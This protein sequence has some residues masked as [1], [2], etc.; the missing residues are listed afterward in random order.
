MT[1][2]LKTA[3]VHA[4]TEP[5]HTNASLFSHNV[6]SFSMWFKIQ[7]HN[8]RIINVPTPKDDGTAEIYLVLHQTNQ[9]KRSP[10]NLIQGAAC[11]RRLEQLISR[12][13]V[14]LRLETSHNH[15]PGTAAPA[16]RFA[17][18]FQCNNPPGQ[19]QADGSLVLHTQLEQNL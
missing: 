4:Q 6:V 5:A 16:R 1:V 19:P 9:S 8:P 14:Q 10:G 15:G 7:L 3:I 2:Q 12:D 11:S 13:P 17:P 18:S